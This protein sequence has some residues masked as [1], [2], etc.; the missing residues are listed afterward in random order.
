MVLG[1]HMVFELVDDSIDEALAGH[2]D[3]ISHYPRRA[4]SPCLT[5]AIRIP[6]EMHK[7]G[8]SA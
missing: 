2:C 5:T 7:E 6:T 8:V 3:I 4:W 1:Y